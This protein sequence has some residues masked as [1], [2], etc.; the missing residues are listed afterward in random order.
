MAKVRQPPLRRANLR[1]NIPIALGPVGPVA[2]R[3]DATT[4]AHTQR[5][6]IQSC[7]AH[8]N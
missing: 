7:A 6:D 8:L 4:S 2:L 1:A 5:A 3:N